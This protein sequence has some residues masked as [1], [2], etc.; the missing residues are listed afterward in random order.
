MRILGLLVVAGLW[1]GC[2]DPDPGPEPIQC[3]VGRS[4]ENE[5]I[6][7]CQS[8]CGHDFDCCYVVDGEWQIYQADCGPCPGQ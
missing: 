6:Q 1:L 4:N 5:C 8:T 7:L 2:S 3:D